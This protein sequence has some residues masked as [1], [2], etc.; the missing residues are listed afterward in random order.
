MKKILYFALCLGLF[1]GTSCIDNREDG[2]MPSKVYLVKSGVQEY[3]ATADQTTASASAWATKSGLLASS[4]EVVY[5]IDPQYLADYNEANGTSFEM[6]PESCYK[7]VQTKFSLTAD[8]INAPFV[9]EYDPSAI[10]RLC[11]A[12][13]VPEKYALPIRIDVTG[14]EVLENKVQVLMTFNISAPTE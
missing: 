14:L 1:V 2:L 12:Y 5:S 7:L 10:Y 3:R 9:V 6:L 4:C 13:N 11:G 8:D